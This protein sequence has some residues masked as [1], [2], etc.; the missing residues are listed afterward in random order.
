MSNPLISIVIPAYNQQRY[1][2]KCVESILNQDLTDF[3]LLI[4]DDASS[5]DTVAICL[6]FAQRDKRVTVIESEHCG[7]SAIRN[8]GIDAA[9]GRYIVFVDSDDWVQSS[10]LSDFFRQP[11]DKSKV[12]VVCQSIFEDY[13]AEVY[14]PFVLYKH[15]MVISD[16]F[17]QN[18]A[19]NRVM[20]DGCP[21]G[22]LF[23]TETIKRYNIRYP[24]G[25]ARNEDHIFVLSYMTRVEQIVLCST[26]NYHYMRY[27][28]T[29]LTFR[30]TSAGDYVCSSRLLMEQI[31]ILADKFSMA[32]QPEYLRALYCD[33]TSA[34]LVKAI[35]RATPKEYEA[36]IAHLNRC[37]PSLRRYFLPSKYKHRSLIKT[38]LNMPES[39]RS[40]YLAV[41]SLKRY[42]Y[43]VQ[44]RLKNR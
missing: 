4:V 10:Y 16:N 5:D 14:R 34:Q 25:L 6:D 2:A 12:T 31:D 43:I 8:K 3:E 9:Q 7:V 29:S 21:V 17:A 24:E 41:V 18:I 44:G 38:M 13:G 11:F 30:L 32:Q 35:Y 36:V 42:F 1:I 40:A 39:W 28:T 22:K 23:D 19:S 27:G 15:D 37:E 33:Y 26:W 20:H